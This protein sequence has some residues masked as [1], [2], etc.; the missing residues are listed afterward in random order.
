M[1]PETE[2][3]LRR[4][5]KPF[6]AKLYALLGVDYGWDSRDHS[7]LVAGSLDSIDGSKGSL[8]SLPTG[9]RTVTIKE[10]SL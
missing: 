2:K 6:N 1:R 9:S 7:H 3:A 5:Y 4:F 8:P 10:G